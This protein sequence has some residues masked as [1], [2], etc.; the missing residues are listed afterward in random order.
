MTLTSQWKLAVSVCGDSICPVC[1][2]YWCTTGVQPHPDPDS[3]QS[4]RLWIGKTAK[5]SHQPHT[6]TVSP[7]H[8][9]A[10]MRATH[11]TDC[12]RWTMMFLSWCQS[13][14]VLACSIHTRILWAPGKQESRRAYDQKRGEEQRKWRGKEN[15]GEENQQREKSAKGERIKEKRRHLNVFVS[16]GLVLPWL[17]FSVNARTIPFLV[18]FRENLTSFKQIS[19]EQFTCRRMLWHTGCLSLVLEDGE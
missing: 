3:Y 17:G 8:Q 1:L 14:W 10:E 13:V 11:R 12:K 19:A 15:R 5:T 2:D 18:T 16:V 7:H 6:H 9:Q 4:Q